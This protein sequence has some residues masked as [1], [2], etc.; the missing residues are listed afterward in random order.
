MAALIVKDSTKVADTLPESLRHPQDIKLLTQAIR[1]LNVSRTKAG[2]YPPDH[3]E[4]TRS[5]DRAYAILQELNNTWATLTLG[6]T[7]DGL[8]LAGERLEPRSAVFKEFAVALS[9]RDIASITLIS[10][11]RREELLHRRRRHVRGRHLFRDRQWRE[12]RDLQERHRLRRRVLIGGTAGP[13]ENG[14]PR[15]RPSEHSMQRNAY[16]C[17]A[18][19]CFF[20]SAMIFSCRLRG[21][22]S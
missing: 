20:D 5:I 14:R 3:P 17:S 22:S 8:L 7:R 13:N 12:R 11:L 4:I 18:S 1:E 15:G 16:A 2:M 10:G 6:V 19:C 9:R 21:T